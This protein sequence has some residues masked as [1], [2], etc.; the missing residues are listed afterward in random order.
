MDR[1]KVLRGDHAFDLLIDKLKECER[2]AL[3]S[4][5]ELE[6]LDKERSAMTSDLEGNTP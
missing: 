1:F 2:L 4:D 3:G 5:S 6:R